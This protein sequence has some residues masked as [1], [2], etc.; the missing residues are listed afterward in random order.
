[1][2]EET[3]LCVCVL[4]HRGD[5][6]VCVCVLGH[7]GDGVVGRAHLCEDLVQPLQR[8]VQV[9]LYPAGG[10][11]DVLAVVLCTPALHSGSKYNYQLG[12]IH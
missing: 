6:V 11:G 10:A 12:H 5:G 1:V 9:H 7:R 4:G 3:G 8:A 2:C